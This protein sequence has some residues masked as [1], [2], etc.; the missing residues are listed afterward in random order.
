MQAAIER[1]AGARSLQVRRAM[2]DAI[3][4]LHLMGDASGLVLSASSFFGRS[5][6]RLMLAG[7]RLDG[8]SDDWQVVRSARHVGGHLDLAERGLPRVRR[9]EFV[10][11]ACCAWWCFAGCPNMQSVDRDPFGH[12]STGGG[13]PH[14]CSYLQ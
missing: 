3:R 11:C 10:M 12:I 7:Q 13:F 9:D 8:S 6:F 5:A 14:G 2:E 4:A 1:C